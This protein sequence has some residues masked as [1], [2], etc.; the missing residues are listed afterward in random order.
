MRVVTPVC[1]TALLLTAACGGS[2]SPTAPATLAAP[3]L[4]S[5][6]DGE[7]LDPLRPTLTVPDSTSDQVGT[8]TYEFQISDT[9]SF[10]WP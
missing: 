8:R 7:Q 5:P 3:A 10:T 9:S 1:L 2:G 6:A 4:Q